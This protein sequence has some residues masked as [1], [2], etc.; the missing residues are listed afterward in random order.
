MDKNI[1]LDLN[2]LT[3]VYMYT[4]TDGVHVEGELI[5]YIDQ[6]PFIVLEK[7]VSNYFIYGY[8]KDILYPAHM[9][10]Y[11]HFIYLKNE[12]YSYS[13]KNYN[14]PKVKDID[15][16]VEIFKDELK[17]AIYKEEYGDDYL[18]I[19]NTC[20][21]NGNTNLQYALDIILQDFSNI[22]EDDPRYN[23]HQY[24]EWY[25]SAKVEIDEYYER[26]EKKTKKDKKGESSDEE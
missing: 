9:V 17:P 3:G 13:Y 2:T 8:D 14:K 7:F 15:A 18:S 4:C 16:F 25:E 6:H 26:L 10:G 22:D 21:E 12:G 20:L 19:L 23:L 1:K 5:G 24:Y 11:D